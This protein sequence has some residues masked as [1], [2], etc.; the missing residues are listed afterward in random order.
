MKKEIHMLLF[1][2]ILLFKWMEL[3]YIYK[4]KEPMSKQYRTLAL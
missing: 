1:N 3:K 2:I 4:K